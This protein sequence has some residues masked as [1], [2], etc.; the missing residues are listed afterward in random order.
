MWIACLPV[1]RSCQDSLRELDSVLDWTLCVPGQCACQDSVRTLT[2][3]SPA[4]SVCVPGQ[5][6]C[7][8]SVRARD[9]LTL[10][11]LLPPLSWQDRNKLILRHHVSPGGRLAFLSPGNMPQ[12]TADCVVRT[13]WKLMALLLQ[14]WLRFPRPV[15]ELSAI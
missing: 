5:C 3:Y 11:Q 10:I 4:Q 7:Q 15:R 6:A 1:Q 9:Y 13:Y 12:I 14:G 8:D 2:G